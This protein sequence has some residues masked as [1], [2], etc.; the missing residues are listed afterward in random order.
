MIIP[1]TQVTTC[2]SSAGHILQKILSFIVFSIVFSVVRT[3][4]TRKIEQLSYNIIYI[5]GFV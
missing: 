1:V 4:V 2:A 3:E 5:Y